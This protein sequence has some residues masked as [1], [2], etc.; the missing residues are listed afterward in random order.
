ME[1]LRKTDPGSRLVILGVGQELDGDDAAGLLVVRRLAT[2]IP[3]QGAVRLIEGGSAPENFLGAIERF[4]PGLVLLIDALDAQE[5][6]GRIFW[7]EE[8]EISG[9]SASTHSLP[10]TLFMDYL[11]S[12]SHSEIGL[13]GIQPEAIAF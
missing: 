11:R 1:R 7:V 10:L 3:A 2:R 5:T 13:I 4:D 8:A 9:F 6:P 12:S